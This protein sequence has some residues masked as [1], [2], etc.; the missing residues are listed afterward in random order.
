MTEIKK[1]CVANWKANGNLSSLRKW[2]DDFDSTGAQAILSVSHPLLLKAV[3]WLAG[4]AEVAAQDIADHG[5]GARTGNTTAQLVADCQVRW[6]LVGHSER[7]QQGESDELCTA[8]LVQAWAAGL[9][10][11]LCVGEMEHE[12]DSGQIEEV[13]TRQLAGIASANSASD[14]DLV[15]AYEPV[16]AIGTGIAASP[17]DAQQACKFINQHLTAK[18]ISARIKVLYGGSV[19]LDNAADYTAMPSIDG[20]LVGGASLDGV[21]FSHICSALAT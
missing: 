14:L 9:R 18:G 2:A 11:I 8:K 7:R 12:R 10:P 3:E 15:V 17:S 4:K 20:L 5:P 6:T 1:I 16:W 19:K 21:S 13:L